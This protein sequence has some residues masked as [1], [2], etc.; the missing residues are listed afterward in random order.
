MKKLLIFMLGL[1]SVVATYAQD[2]YWYDGKKMQLQEV[3]TEY[4]IC[5][6]DKTLFDYLEKSDEAIQNTAGISFPNVNKQAEIDSKL[7]GYFYSIVP[8]TMINKISQ[9]YDIPY[10]TTNYRLDGSDED[11][12][13]SNV[14]HVKLKS[15]DD[16]SILQNMA[17]QYDVTIVGNNEFSPLW[18]SLICF[19]TKNGNAIQL[20]NLFYESGA[21]S[22]SEPDLMNELIYGNPTS[23]S[24]IVSDEKISL[25]NNNNFS[26]NVEANLSTSYSIVSINVYNVQGTQVK[27]IALS[28]VDSI[29]E[30]IE[31]SRESIGLYIVV[32]QAE[33]K[34]LLSEKILIGK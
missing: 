27:R 9:D 13:V 34:I 2:Y 30:K 17:E 1:V 3:E 29:N 7:N 19:S 5:Y 6:T 15:E 14:F 10:I 28:N 16:F 32:V 31:L 21:F 8:A 22:A 25:R 26:L 23:I 4:F 18:Y 33:G 12:C 11:F 24:P 20:A